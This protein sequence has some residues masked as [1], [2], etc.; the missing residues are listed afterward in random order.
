MIKSDIENNK[1]I[2]KSNIKY[3]KHLSNSKKDSIQMVDSI[4]VLLIIAEKNTIMII[5]IILVIPA[6][7]PQLWKNLINFLNYIIKKPL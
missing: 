7:C 4:L 1:I 2:T 5:F 6:I 3:I